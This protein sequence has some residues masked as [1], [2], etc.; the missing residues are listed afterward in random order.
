MITSRSLVMFFF[1]YR[2]NIQHYHSAEQSRCTVMI[3]DN[4]NSC[5]SSE[6]KDRLNTNFEIPTC[7]NNA[8]CRRAFNI[9]YIQLIPYYDM[10]DLIGE[11]IDFCCGRCAAMRVV[12]N[13]SH[14]Y[15]TNMN[16]L[17][18]SD[19]VFPVLGMTSS[20]QMYGFHF[21]P[22]VQAPDTLYITL[23]KKSPKEIITNL[24]T[25]CANMWPLVLISVLLSLISGFVAWCGETWNNTQEFP[26]AFHVG[27]F[28]GMF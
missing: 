4:F 23:G 17:S 14:T 7:R 13:F 1:T 24:I 2:L 18:T 27:L 10:K 20:Q 26:R 3:N 12:H 16:V 11:M 22:I 19:F 8:I 25:T 5:E 28:Q 9:S 21:V 15:Q 6:G